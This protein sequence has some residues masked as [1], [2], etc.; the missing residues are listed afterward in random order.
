MSRRYLQH[1]V[2]T[3]YLLMRN[4]IIERDNYH[5]LTIIAIKRMLKEENTLETT[6]ETAKS[7]FITLKTMEILTSRTSAVNFP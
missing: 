4:L 5:K 2:K 7:Y 6:I 1:L 3:Q